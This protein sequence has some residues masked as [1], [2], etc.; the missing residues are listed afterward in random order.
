MIANVT[1]S[2]KVGIERAD[3]ARYLGFQ[4]S[5]FRLAM[6]LLSEHVLHTPHEHHEHE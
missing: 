3:I 5:W 6:L 2:T 4:V 1:E